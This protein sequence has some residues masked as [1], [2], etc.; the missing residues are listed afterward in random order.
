ML[1]ETSGS[2]FKTRYEE[3]CLNRV[4]VAASGLCDWRARLADP[5][6]HWKRGASAFE[7]AVSW[8]LAQR[9]VRGIPPA[10]AAVLDGYDLSRSAAAVLVVPEHKVKVPGKGKPSQNDA[11]VLAR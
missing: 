8:E 10:V 9:T 4:L 2:P 11:W 7:T 6:L 3:T 1:W 5:E